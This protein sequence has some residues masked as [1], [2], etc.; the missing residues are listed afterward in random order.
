MSFEGL[1]H[2]DRDNG[3][4]RVDRATMTSPEILAAERAN[5]FDRYWLYLGHEG[6]IERPG[7][8]RRKSR[9]GRPLIFLRNTDGELDL[10]Y[11]TC[12]H[13]GATICREEA[14][15]A[16]RFTCFYHAW[17]FN[18]HG[19]LIA[20]PDEDG[21][22][23]GF[24][25]DERSL[26]RPPQLDSYRGF[27][28]VSFNPDVES[29]R[30][31]L[32]GATEFIDLVVDQA[33]EGMTVVKGS[34]RY[35]TKANW[36]L[37]IE[38]SI[39][40]YHGLPVHQTYFA[41]V[42]S[43]GGGISTANLVGRGPQQLG[44]GHAVLEGEAPYG[45]PIARWDNLFGPDAKEEIEAIRRRLVNTFGEERASRM[46]DNFRN[47][48]IFPNFI[49]NDITAITARYIEPV[50]PDLL[51]TDAWALAP[52][53]ERGAR[54]ARRIDSYLT[55]IGPGGFATP[56]DVEALESCQKGFAAHPGVEWSDISRGMTRQPTVLDELQ[57]RAWWRAWQA[58]MSGQP[59]PC[60]VALPE[61]P[62]L[63]GGS[64]P[65]RIG[66]VHDVNE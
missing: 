63:A 51:N 58:A 49:L 13:R 25:R 3:V 6:E 43:L 9:N 34:N 47:M 2:D 10:F 32:G 8:F 40:G 24:D 45:R 64:Q 21:Y 65:A 30:E 17:S 60:P 23:P 7:D 57:I 1:I 37:L 16:K 54:L 42:K 20:L 26:R 62:Q 55:F 5:L 53:E 66:A 38:N 29:L 56:D 36:K 52:K 4:F 33:E 11:D 39:D 41:Y 35:A 15:N 31:Y 27:Y 22:G 50:T 44:N 28:F 46:A 19:K 18:T 59:L 48:V 14:G 61:T 12:P